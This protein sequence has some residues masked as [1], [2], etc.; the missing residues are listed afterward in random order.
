MHGHV[1]VDP[2]DCALVNTRFT[3]G[4]DLKFIQPPAN[5]DVYKYSFFLDAIRLWNNLPSN[6]THAD[7][8][9]KFKLYLKSFLHHLQLKYTTYCVDCCIILTQVSFTIIILL[10]LLCRPREG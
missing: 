1:D 5:I 4:N 8:V 6:I 9:E 7:S 3:R 10:L 2:P